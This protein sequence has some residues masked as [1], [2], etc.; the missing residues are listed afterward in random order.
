ML[1]PGAARNLR[2]QIALLDRQTGPRRINQRVLG[3]WRTCSLN[4]DTQQRHRP[5][6][7][8]QRFRAAEPD[9][10]VQVQ[11]GR[12]KSMYRRRCSL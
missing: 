7:Y 4:Q 3:D 5:L 12:A 10:G 9:F 6:A 1:A 11:A 8:R 2:R